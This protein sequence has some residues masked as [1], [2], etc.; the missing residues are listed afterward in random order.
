MSKRNLIVVIFCTVVLLGSSAPAA[1]GQDQPEST[2]VLYT[3]PMLTTV[4]DSFRP[5]AHIGG[6]GNRGLEYGDSDNQIV[7]AAAS[8]YVTHAGPVGGRKTITIEHLDGVRTTYTG[9]LELWVV[10]EMTVRQGSAIA[11]A[12]RGFHF[13]ARILDHYLDPQILLDASAAETRA[14]L[15]PVD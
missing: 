10:E 12:S 8:G 7:A 13:G 15:V 11:R 1:H 6:P 14:R 2:I 3:A 5:P 4:V 9:L